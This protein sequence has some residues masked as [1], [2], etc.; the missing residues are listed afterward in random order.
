MTFE[1]WRGDILQIIVNNK[2]KQHKPELN[3]RGGEGV[4]H[5][6]KKPKHGDQPAGSRKPGQLLYI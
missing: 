3:H 2:H 5:F 6:H 1:G 4:A